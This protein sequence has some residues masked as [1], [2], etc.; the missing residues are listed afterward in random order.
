MKRNLWLNVSFSVV[1]L[2]TSMLPCAYALRDAACGAP[3]RSYATAPTYPTDLKIL[4]HRVHY[5]LC[6]IVSTLLSSTLS[7]SLSPLCSSYVDKQSCPCIRTV[8]RAT[9]RA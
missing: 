2:H 3:W 5:A 1:D 8:N 9:Q 4:V 6:I 7:L